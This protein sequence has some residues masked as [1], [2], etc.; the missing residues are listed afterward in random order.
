MYCSVLGGHDGFDQVLVIICGSPCFWGILTRALGFSCFSVPIIIGNMNPHSATL[1]VP[2]CDRLKHRLF[3]LSSGRWTPTILIRDHQVSFSLLTPNGYVQEL[4]KHWP[5][6]HLPRLAVVFRRLVKIFLHQLVTWDEAADG[7]QLM[8]RGYG[9]K[10]PGEW[11][12]RSGWLQESLPG[13]SGSVH[14]YRSS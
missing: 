5:G 2:D 1:S 6:T 10:T 14:P 13:C 7:W 12:R 8:T 4:A 9:E 3:S 11:N